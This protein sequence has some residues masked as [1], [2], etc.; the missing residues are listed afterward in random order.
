LQTL[1]RHLEH[2][3][4]VLAVGHLPDGAETVHGV[5]ADIAVELHELLVREAVIGLADRHELVAVGPLAPDPEGVVGVEGRALSVAAL[6]IHHHGVDEVRITFPFV[7][8]ALRAPGQIGA[9]GPLH[10]AALDGV[11][12]G[13][14]PDRGRVGA[15]R[16]E[17]LKPGDTVRIEVPGIGVLENPVE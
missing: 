3:A 7:P 14:R 6:A 12:I 2:E 10:H 13:S 9:V 16:G 5:V 4:A 1:E 15:G 17:F 8:V 11:R